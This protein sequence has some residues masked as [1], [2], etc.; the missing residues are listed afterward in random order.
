MWE[1]I[2]KILS[3]GGD[4]C[5][6]VE[7]EESYVII[8]W[9]DYEKMIDTCST[10][11]QEANR[12]ID[13]WKAEENAKGELNEPEVNKEVEDKTEVKIEDLPF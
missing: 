8:K 12:N 1:K 10:E 2:K 5:I 13:H 7:N 9:E 11:T 6:I 3:K 4:R